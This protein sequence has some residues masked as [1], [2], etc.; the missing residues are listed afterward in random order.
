MAPNRRITHQKGTI[1]SAYD[2]ITSPENAAVVRSVA[3]FGAAV[4]FLASSWADLLL[5]PCVVF[6]QSNPKSPR[7]STNM[8]QPIN[9]S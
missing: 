8:L 2:A 4:A 1:G 9:P 3:V 7:S 6:H 5:P